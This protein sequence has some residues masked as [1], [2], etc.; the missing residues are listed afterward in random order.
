MKM[1]FY[2][3][4]TDNLGIG[5]SMK[6]GT[7]T[8]ES[9][10][11][12]GHRIQKYHVYENNI[13]Y[14][15]LIR[16]VMDKY[17]SGYKQ[18]LLEKLENDPW[19]DN[20]SGHYPGAP[21]G[22]SFSFFH[23]IFITTTVKSFESNDKRIRW[24]IEQMVNAHRHPE[25]DYDK[26]HLRWLKEGHMDFKRWNQYQEDDVSLMKM[27]ELE[28][29]YFL[30]LKDLSDPKFL[31]WL[32][33]K[34][35]KWKEY[36]GYEMAPGVVVGGP[37]DPQGKNEMWYHIPYHHE[38]IP[39]INKT[40]D[41]FWKNMDLFWKEYTEGKIVKGILLNLPFY[42][43]ESPYIKS[44]LKDIEL[45]QEVVDNIRKYNKRYIKL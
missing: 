4:G 19:P 14:V 9:M 26:S 22:H 32:Q 36:K 40:P 1:P 21:A 12:E 2:S 11:Y 20:H 29:I 43:T 24:G 5:V 23:R 3:I 31:E 30:E 44:I 45:E 15:V 27:S 7:G 18:D 6:M 13:K 37:D 42:P 34:D 25:V 8:L 33:E 35:E 39:H 41:Y 28:N 17:K 10:V 38:S 16:D